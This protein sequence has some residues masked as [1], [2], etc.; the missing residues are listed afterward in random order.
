MTANV[1]ARKYLFKFIYQEHYILYRNLS[2]H[3]HVQLAAS[4]L[5]YTYLH[6]VNFIIKMYNFIKA[7]VMNGCKY[8]IS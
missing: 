4:Y 2:I 5:F 1:H 7:N 8:E 6:V 3:V